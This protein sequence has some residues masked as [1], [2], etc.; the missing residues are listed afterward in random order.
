MRRTGLSLLARITGGSLLIA[1]LISGVAGVLLYEQVRRI[2]YQ[3]EQA[4]LQGME[5]PYRAAIQQEST[6]P[7]DVP[8][9][10][11]LL[12]VVDPSGTDRLDNLPPPLAGRLPELVARPEGTGEVLSD[13]MP[14]LVRVAHVSASGGVWHIVS[15]RDTRVQSALLEQ[16]AALLVA[17]LVIL[18]LGFAGASWLIGRAAL[19]PVSRMRMS[20][21][22]LILTSGSELLP[23]GPAE[24]EIA[25]LART[26]NELLTD[27]RAS[28]ER[29]RQVVSDASHELR[30]PLAILHSQLELAQ[31]EA[32]TLPDMRRDVAAAQRTLARLSALATSLL[33]LSRIDAQSVR[34][35]ATVEELASELGNAVDRGRLHVDGRQVEI[36]FDVTLPGGERDVIAISVNDFGRVVDNLVQNALAAIGP[37]GRVELSLRQ[38]SGGVALSVADDGGGMDPGFVR[39][40]TERFSREDPSRRGG[41]AGL[42]L[43]IVD[44][45]VSVAHGT[46]TIDNRPGAGLTVTVDLPYLDPGE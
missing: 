2:V 17:S 30:T 28:A 41:G 38:Y 35:R 16:V 32:A 12:A 8:A 5:A 9:K 39:H 14:Y 15:A 33:E 31:V 23:V 27:L 40:A 7:M 36:D 21:E 20:A 46:V 4:I 11:Q 26:L 19:R 37:A 45:I 34:G 42:G 1:V 13:G 22:S 18:N 24:D 43:S 3:G 10:G 6:E 44:A 25:R 29:E